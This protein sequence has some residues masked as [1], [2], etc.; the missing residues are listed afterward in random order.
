MDDDTLLMMVAQ[1]LIDDGI[2]ANLYQSLDY[3]AVRCNP[4]KGVHRSMC[5]HILDGQILVDD[6][7]TYR[8]VGI[9]TIRYANI[10][11]SDPEAFNKLIVVCHS[12]EAKRQTKETM[13]KPKAVKLR[14]WWIPQVPGKPFLREV[15]NYVEAKL[16]LDAL[17]EYDKFQHKHNIKGDYSNVG[18]LQAWNKD[19]KDYCDWHPDEKE[20][21]ILD[22]IKADLSMN[23]DPL[24]HMTMDQVRKFQEAL[25]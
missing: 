18:G 11:I 12:K 13:T 3:V 5:V 6:A 19:A 14:V 7:G 25:K 20:S 1:V 23:D 22:A 9:E 2:E 24:D 4:S 17:A 15:K 16:L 10:P 8:G 21:A